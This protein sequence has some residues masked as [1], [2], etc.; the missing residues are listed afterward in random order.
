MRRPLASLVVAA[1]FALACGESGP[2]ASPTTPPASPPSTAGRFDVTLQGA[3][4]DIGAVLLRPEIASGVLRAA[5]VLIHGWQPAGV[6]GALVLEPRARTFMDAGYVVLAISMRGWPPSG[7]RDDCG[8]RQPDDVAAAVGWLASQPG[9]DPDRLAVVGFSQ[10]GQVA[11]LSAVRGARVRAIVA[12]YPVT[13]V[14]LWK[15]TTANADIPGY[16]TS[17]CEPG[18]T[19]PRSPRLNATAIGAPVLLVHGDMDTRVPTDQS[20]LMK[21]ALDTAG[22]S[23]TLFLVPGAQHGFTA[24]EEATVRPVVDQFLAAS[25]R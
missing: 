2:P 18:G 16:V 15:Q 11:L 24:A 5:I 13:D 10:G 20:V 23:V 17:V 4:V 8:L 7:G 1:G 14:A 25:L 21:A 6:N 22:R 9:V 19:T 12:Y 3:G